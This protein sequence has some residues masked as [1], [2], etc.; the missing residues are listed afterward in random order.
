MNHAL[1][2]HYR[3]IRRHQL[4]TYGNSGLHIN[5]VDQRQ[6]TGGSASYGEHALSAYNAAVSHISFVKRLK[7]MQ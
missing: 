3:R 7:A 4:D 1:R 6:H 5:G 2:H